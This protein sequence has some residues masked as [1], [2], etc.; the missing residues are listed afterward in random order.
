VVVI[1]NG[2][3]FQYI[4]TGRKDCVID[5]CKKD[6]LVAVRLGAIDNVIEIN[7]KLPSFDH[8]NYKSF[9]S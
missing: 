4:L 6:M 1:F 2:Q 5:P 7:Q 8:F 9:L 3:L